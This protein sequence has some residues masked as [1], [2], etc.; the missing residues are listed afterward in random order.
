MRHFAVIVLGCFVLCLGQQASIDIE[1]YRKL[2][3]YSFAERPVTV[4]KHTFRL[5]NIKPPAQSDTNCI[6]AVVID[7][8]K[9]ILFDVDVAGGPFG[10]VVPKVQPI[11]DGLIVLKASPYDAKTFFLLSNG[12]MVTLPGA[13]VVVDTAGKCAYCVWDNDNTFRLTVLDY[14]SL[15]LVIPTTAIPRPKQWYSTGMTYC[16][17]TASDKQYYTVDLMTKAITQSAQA[18]GTPV[19]VSYI[20]ETEKM[21]RA[22]CCGAEVLKQ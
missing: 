11:P 10:L 3:Q 14:R 16:F 21:N 20:A 4:G 15:R 12:K 8:R 6:S 13:S 2:K 18:D 1:K 17:T 7:K 19:P 5:I 9:Y 22:K